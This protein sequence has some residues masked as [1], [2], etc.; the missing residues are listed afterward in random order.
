MEA[1]LKT[2][3]FAGVSWFKVD[4][5]SQ[6]AVLQAFKVSKQSTLIMF[7]GDKEIARSTGQTAPDAIAG[8]IRKAL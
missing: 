7:R 4:F 1:L 3:E 2:P 6:D 5:D 8:L